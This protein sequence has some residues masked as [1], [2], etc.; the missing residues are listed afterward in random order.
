MPGLSNST[1]L[2]QEK[3]FPLNPNPLSRL[4]KSRFDSF[5]TEV[6]GL[7]RAIHPDHGH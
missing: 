1:G 5:L 3:R 4:F 6:S 2:A 7:V